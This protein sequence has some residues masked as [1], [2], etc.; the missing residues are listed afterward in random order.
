MF[1]KMFEVEFKCN[2]CG[3]SSKRGVFCAP[4]EL[5]R[6]REW[7][8][9]FGVCDDCKMLQDKAVSEFIEVSSMCQSHLDAESVE[10][11]ST[12]LNEAFEK[13][14]SLKVVRSIYD[15]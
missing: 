12:K 5:K 3:H 2:L 14:V 8:D 7:L 6:E 1:G 10:S 11:L 15:E 13:C 4:W 9:M